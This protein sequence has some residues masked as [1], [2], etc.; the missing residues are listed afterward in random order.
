[1]SADTHTSLTLEDVD[2]IN[3][4]RQRLLNAAVLLELGLYHLDDEEVGDSES[5]QLALLDVVESGPRGCDKDHRDDRAGRQA[6]GRW[7]MRGQPSSFE[8]KLSRL[9]AQLRTIEQAVDGPIEQELRDL[10]VRQWRLLLILES[11]PR[12][13]P[14]LAPA[15]HIEKPQVRHDLSVLERAGFPIY[16]YRDDYGHHWWGLLRRAPARH[17]DVEPE[18][19]TV[20]AR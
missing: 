4:C 13:V 18:P 5:I 15:L 1:M 12:S 8:D 19:A 16:D 6:I 2:T 14:E 17:A 20:V 3:G 10:I 9:K 7:P 11:R